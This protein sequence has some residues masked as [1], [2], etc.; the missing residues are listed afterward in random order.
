MSESWRPEEDVDHA[1]SFIWGPKLLSGAV[2]EY[3]STMIY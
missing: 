1:P 2:E 3:T